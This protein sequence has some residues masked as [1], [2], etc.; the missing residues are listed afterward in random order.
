M[1]T[2]TL[3]RKPKL[4]FETEANPSHVT[5]DDGKES[6]RNI[7]WH[8]Y[9]EARWEYAEPDVIFVEIAEWVVVLRGHNLGPLFLA[10]EMRTLL[11]IRAQPEL[12]QEREREADTF[13]VEIC[14]SKTTGIG[15]APKSGGQ[16]EFGL[17]E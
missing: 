13:V 7:P 14:I 2:A 9:V 10:I 11:R 12:A 4:H 17:G 1:M 3:Q 5:F 15:K 8:H 16:I 6:R